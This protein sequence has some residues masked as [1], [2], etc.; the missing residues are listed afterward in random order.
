MYP[1]MLEVRDRPCLVVGG[2]GVALRKVEG[3][4][5]DGARVTV[6]A[7]EVVAPLAAM[8]ERGDIRWERRSYRERE[9]AGFTLAFATT[10]RREVNAMVSRDA[11]EAGV[12]VNAADDPLLCSF[13]LPARIRRGPL[14]LAVGSAGE[15]PFVVRRL[16]Q[17]LE[18]RFGEE[19]GEWL[20]AAARFRSRVRAADLARSERE[21][22]Y[23]RFFEAT[24][25]GEGL[26]CRVPT[27]SEQD[28]WLEQPAE[29]SAAVAPHLHAPV[30][31]DVA[32]HRGFVSLV[33]AGPGCAGL[34]TVRGRQRLL[35][36]DAVVYDRLAA[37]ALPC[38]LPVGVELHPVGKVAG[39][40]PTPQQEINALLVRLAQRG[41]RVVRLK[42]GDPYVFGRG[43]EE[44]EALEAEGIA[45]EVV[46]GVTAGVAV[47]CWA[48]IPATHRRE[49]V[50]FTL[51]TAHEA[52]KSHGP[53]VRWELLARDEH[54]TVV[55]YMGVTALP[56]VVEKLLG[57][58]MAPDTPAAMIQQGTTS[59]QRQ[60]VTTLVDLPDAV[61][62]A[63]LGAPGLFVIGPTVRHAARLDWYRRLPLAH[64]RIVVAA[65]ADHLVTALSDAGA[66]VVAVPIPITPAARIVMAALPLTGC[67]VRDRAEVDWLDDER[68]NPGFGPQAVTWCIGEEAAERARDRGWQRLRFL[69]EGTADER[70][71][72]ELAMAG[73]TTR[74]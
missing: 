61:Q 46:P 49:A 32:P 54:A 62:N 9:A 63:G 57:A 55:G 71:V 73:V 10:D 36:A 13:H 40:H 34:I 45:F 60:V 37:A 50:R 26:R 19:W 30:S 67:V 14:Q 15:A 33:G 58:G 3:L 56:N 18:R 41:L 65:A 28:G 64:Q 48:G 43:G 8:A 2:G 7:P 52:I 38:E 21:A 17:V 51:L 12:W 68:D 24:V 47:P 22:R 44:A 29:D 70:L 6:V 25:D 11:E 20:Q 31:D 4:V 16:R 53:Q 74:G 69:D 35:E 39:N 5:E 72:A 1:V 27:E 42:G 23:D 66:D 59:A